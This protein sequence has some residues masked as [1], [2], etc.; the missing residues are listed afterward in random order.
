MLVKHLFCSLMERLDGI[1]KDWSE[2]NSSS[3]QEKLIQEVM[4]LRKVS[5]DILDQWLIFEE[6]MTKLQSRVQGFQVNSNNLDMEIAEMSDEVAEKIFKEIMN[7][8]H[9]PT[10][11]PEMVSV[12]SGYAAHA[13]R[14]GQGY[15]NLL[16][17]GQAA[18]HFREVLDEDPEL[19]V[20]RLYLGF[21]HMMNG[22]WEEAENQLRFVSRTTEN[23]LL[24]ATAL[25]AYGS[26][27]AGFGNSE[28]ALFQ[29]EG[30]IEA[31]PKLRD[32]YFNKALV[33]M[34]LEQYQDALP[35]W[36]MLANEFKD[37]WEI[38]L[39]LSKCYQEEGMTDEA[40]QTLT[41]IIQIS[42]DPDL[43]WQAGQSFEN[44]RQFGNATVCYR[45]ILERDP[46]NAAAWH[47]L[48]WN[49]WHA[50]GLPVGINYIKKAMS[51][52]PTNPD[53]QF[54]YGWIMHHIQDYEE[55]QK[56]FKQILEQEGRYP[57]AIAGLVHVHM[58][59]QEWN[60]A[61]T[62]AYQ[63]ISDMHAPT[64]GLGLLQLG[65]VSLTRGDYATAQKHLEQSIQESP[66][67]PDS[68]LWLGLSRYMMGEK[69]E[70]LRI[71]EYTL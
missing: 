62:Y 64:R 8:E 71:W 24:K 1:E 69:D 48:G 15:Y 6:R 5:D 47:G 56:V 44:L 27:L 19:D 3:V 28:L 46:E 4:E 49:M 63:L 20:A 66:N 18:E 33:M 67:M 26:L 21:S 60:E 61:E 45:L 36:K 70:A 34:N 30:A 10:N 31:Y 65:K 68:Y 53:Y 42:Q 13:F 55:A 17:Y 16:M 38:Y 29:F 2:T 57:L 51:L 23:R 7:L 58:A 50:E 25:N 39:Q 35:I 12:L 9:K 32:P 59:R 14:K 11:K 40:E 37:D 54:S 52:S 22:E 41:E 43:L